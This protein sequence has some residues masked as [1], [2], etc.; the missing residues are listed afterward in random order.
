MQIAQV[1]GGYTLGAADLL[2]R[3][4]GKKNKEEMAK[5]RDVFIAGAEKNGLSRTK[6]TALF[7]LMEKFAGYGFNKSHSAAYA[8][9]AYQTAYFKAH[10]P[11]AFMA[12]NL[13]LVMDDTDKVRAL[14]DDAVANGLAILPPDVNASNYRFEPVDR[15]RIR[16]G[17]GGVKGTGEQAIEAIVAARE[18]GGPFRDLFD[19]C[20]RV[21]KRHVNRRAVEALVQSGAFD[22]MEPRRAM[23]LAS[24]GVALT[25]A[26]KAER[27]AAQVSLFG[28]SREEAGQALVVARE[29]TEAERL[30]HEKAALGFYLSGHP[31]AAFAQEL[32]PLIR[33]SLS[34]LQPRKEPVL[35]AGVVL[36]VRVQTSRRGK[37]AI[38]TLDDGGAAVEVVV[39]NEIYDAA[40]NTLR[41]DELV[42]VEAKVM[43]SNGEDGQAAGPA[44]RRGCRARPG[45]GP[46]ALCQ[47]AAP[48]VQRRRRRRA[49]GR[50]ADAVPPR[51]LPDRRRVSQPRRRRRARAS[52]RVAREPR[53]SAARPSQGLARAGK[54]EGG[55]LADAPECARRAGG[56]AG[57]CGSTGISCCCGARRA[58]RRSARGSRAPRCPWRRSSRPAPA[59]T[60][61][62][63]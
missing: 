19:F 61:S 48:R 33:L 52:R 38:V 6:A 39:Y 1:I 25:E 17:L 47:G 44:H 49:V 30:A 51:Q 46:Q 4:M 59:R 34:D 21:D 2:R 58:S 12:A 14:Y 56:R 3:A 63:F 26:E 22:T 54:R 27:S 55:V 7:D 15:A 28:D 43:Q 10:H 13:S 57:A 8:L 11:A 23:L 62:A 36:G 60:I 20:R 45:R 31:Y 16:Y 32:S 29:W 53:G 41:E 9:I 37:M 18:A 35:I 40:R 50:D 24:V 42:V 5:H